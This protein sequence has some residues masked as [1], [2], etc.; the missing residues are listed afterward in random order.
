MRDISNS[1][2]LDT[3]EKRALDT[4]HDDMI[5]LANQLGEAARVHNIE[6]F[7][8]L[9]EST[10]DRLISHMRDEHSVIELISEISAK[11]YSK[12]NQAIEVQ[13][14][15]ILS[16]LEHKQDPKTLQGCAEELRRI[17]EREILISNKKKRE[18]QFQS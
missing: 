12:L 15:T 13:G 10:V 7:L 14:L 1:D 5:Y 18:V 4:D 11:K 2:L 17:I 8:R 16:L 9:A 6:L 3:S